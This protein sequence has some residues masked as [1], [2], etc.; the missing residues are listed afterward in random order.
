MLSLF[1]S[2]L[3]YS[4]YGITFLRVILAL[5]LASHAFLHLKNAWPS[6]DLTSIALSLIEGALAIFL[7]LGLFTQAAALLVA[8]LML[9]SL[10]LNYRHH[11]SYHSR[12]YYLLL[13]AIALSL[14]VLGP[15]ALA[16]DYPL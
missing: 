2:L 6:R 16:I 13:I 9:V 1:P 5:A 7:F 4:F 3:D 8:I 14:L 12:T 10:I 15:G 11:D